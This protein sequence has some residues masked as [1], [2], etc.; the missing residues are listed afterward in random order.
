MWNMGV[1]VVHS[2]CV[3]SHFAAPACCVSNNLKPQDFTRGLSCPS[4]THT[5]THT[6]IHTQACTYTHFWVIVLICRLVSQ[7]TLQN[8]TAKKR[9]VRFCESSTSL[10][11]CKQYLC[12]QAATERYTVRASHTNAKSARVCVFV[13]VCVCVWEEYEK[14]SG[15]VRDKSPHS[16]LG[17]L[18]CVVVAGR[19]LRNML[20]II[21]TIKSSPV[22]QASRDWLT[23]PRQGRKWSSGRRR[24]NAAEIRRRV[25]QDGGGPGFNAEPS[26][27]KSKSR[28]RLPVPLYWS[29]V[30]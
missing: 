12:R 10:R 11:N 5:H 26:Q 27:V 8:R 16:I 7:H 1:V 23:S 13:C 29:D 30:F 20:Q 24:Q 6:H 4:E 14:S 17:Y 18:C 9:A 22:E 15:R 28:T 19:K 21:M 2:V 3:C 25:E